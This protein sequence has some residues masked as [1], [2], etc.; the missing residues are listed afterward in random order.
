[1]LRLATGGRTDRGIFIK[2]R[3]FR[4]AGESVTGCKIYENCGRQCDYCAA[5][6]AKKKA[7]KMKPRKTT[8]FEG[9]DA[10]KLAAKNLPNYETYK[11]PMCNRIVSRHG[12]IPE[13]NSRGVIIS[14]YCENCG[15][16]L[17]TET[18]KEQETI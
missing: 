3:E 15:Q 13:L 9:K 2:C 8:I 1:M 16:A 12:Y 6:E 18:T 10:E 5:E 17:D 4:K 14:N 7:K 11:C